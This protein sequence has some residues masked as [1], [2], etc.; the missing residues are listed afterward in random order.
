MTTIDA[1]A[2]PHIL[3]DVLHTLH[4]DG[5]HRTLANFRQTSSAM[6]QV[7]DACLPHRLILQKCTD[8][9]LSVT[10]DTRF[11]AAL[12]E[13][14]RRPL[15]ENLIDVHPQLLDSASQQQ[16]TQH[17]RV[18]VLRIFDC[19]D[20]LPPVPADMVIIFPSALHFLEPDHKDSCVRLPPDSERTIINMRFNGAPGSKQPP[21][22]R[23]AYNLKSSPY[24]LQPA[25]HKRQEL[26]LMFTRA[27]S[28]SSLETGRLRNW[29]ASV[30]GALYANPLLTVT[31]IIDGW[32]WLWFTAEKE[33]E[34][35]SWLQDVVEERERLEQAWHY[36]FIGAIVEADEDEGWPAE[37]FHGRVELMSMEEYET[38][39]GMR[40]SALVDAG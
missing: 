40:M 18:P 32:D 37:L 29:T 36:H 9:T 34:E 1:L 20:Q 16:W 4:Q 6:R 10:A 14:W 22:F 24:P 7:I 27:S 25:L 30:V 2:Y 11:W 19:Q 26:V 28:S 8:G 15:I 5:Q 31:L 21:D 33:V 17:R 39:A 35:W 12:T 23:F 38:R 13:D 3:D